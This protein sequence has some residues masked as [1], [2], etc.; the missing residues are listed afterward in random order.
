MRV[1]IGR[2]ILWISSLFIILFMLSTFAGQVLAD[3]PQKKANKNSADKLRHSIYLIDKEYQGVNENLQWLNLKI[4]RL[5]AMNAPVQQALYSSVDYKKQKL[6]ALE[7]ERQEYEKYL[8]EAIA[9]QDLEKQKQIVPPAPPVTSV[10]PAPTAPVNDIMSGMEGNIVKQMENLGLSDSFELISDSQG[11]KI[12][13]RCPILFTSGSAVVSKEYEPFLI[14]VFSLVKDQK[15]WIV[16]DGYADKNSIKT[17]KYP[18]NFELGAIRAAN[19]VH[20]LVG[21]GV[22]ADVFKVASTGKYRFPDA[23]PM[24]EKKA[25]ERYVNLTI[26]F[27]AS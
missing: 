12:Q 3:I 1:L 27:E 26:R 6:A 22:P 21:K 13:T 20:A 16:V 19:V 11:V 23:R 17:K 7:K 14:K 15:V 2:R 5:K 10:L 8:E 9:L 18:S 4:V 25:D 24:A